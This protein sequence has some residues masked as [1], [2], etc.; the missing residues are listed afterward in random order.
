MNVNTLWDVEMITEDMLS[1]F[2]TSDRLIEDVSMVFKRYL[3][4]EIDW[5]NR[6]I[7]LKGARGVGKTTILK[8]RI[9]EAFGIGS[10][11]ALYVSLDDL[12]FSRH[13]I[14]EVA[15]Y[16]YDHGFTH[17]FIDEIHHWTVLVKVF[18]ATLHFF[19]VVQKCPDIKHGKENDL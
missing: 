3:M 12:W 11:R 13:S 17:L 14:L 5:D 7:C 19:D 1:L 6:L 2:K 15:S 8:Q 16:L 10:D 9:K 18:A 4:Q